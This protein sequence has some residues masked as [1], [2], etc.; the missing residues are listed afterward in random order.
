MKKSFPNIKVFPYL[1][2]AELL[3]DFKI[4]PN[5]LH[6]VSGAETQTAL[7]DAG[8]GVWGYNFET[9]DVSFDQ[10]MFIL[11][12]FEVTTAGVDIGIWLERISALDRE[13][14]LKDFMTSIQEKI[15]FDSQYRI[16]VPGGVF[17]I[18]RSTGRIHTDVGSQTHLLGVC[19]DIT[20]QVSDNEKLEAQNLKE[21]SISR[22][23]SLSRLSAGIA[24]EINNPLTIILGH[25]ENLLAAAAKGFAPAGE[26]SKAATAILQSCQRVSHIVRGL[27]NFARD[28]SQDPVQL[29]S[30]ATIFEHVLALCR[31]RFR[32]QQIDLQ[33][34][35]PP[36][37]LMAYCRS[38]EVEQAL[39]YLLSYAFDT[40]AHNKEKWVQLSTR[41]HVDHVAISLVSSKQ[42]ISED[43]RKQMID[44]LSALDIGNDGSHLGLSTA[45]EI[46]ESVQ[47]Q[48]IID[49]VSQFF[50][51]IIELPKRPPE[52]G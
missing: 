12:G 25:A 43:V 32:N 5:H 46:I 40:A 28:G 41:E 8:I 30:L 37:D 1:D 27:R 3:Q 2:A 15:P 36:T 17:R 21:G 47:G 52:G 11:F 22:A 39:F 24:H 31:S 50:R 16:A 42:G 38:T 6:P 18:V 45:K 26:V 49:E 29:A 7:A 34:E 9:Q 33:I 19:I 4:H 51:L 14:T 48:M 10:N 20:K 23:N 44:P 35:M 13:R